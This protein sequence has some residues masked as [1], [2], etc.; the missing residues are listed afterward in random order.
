MR[1]KG[2]KSVLSSQKSPAHGLKNKRYS[3][4]GFYGHMFMEDFCSH[5]AIG[6]STHDHYNF[7]RAN[8]A[9]LRSLLQYD[10]YDFLRYDLDNQLSSVMWELLLCGKSYL[11]VVTKETTDGTLCGISFIPLRVQRA[12]RCGKNYYFKSFEYDDSVVSFKIPISNVIVFDLKDM[13]FGRKYFVRLLRRMRKTDPDLSLITQKPSG[14]SYLERENKNQKQRLKINKRIHWNERNYQNEHISEAYF[15]Y[16][17]VEYKMLRLR[18]LN[19]LIG[20]YNKAVGKIGETSGF[21]G[22][23]EIAEEIPDYNECLEKLQ[24]GEYCFEQASK[25]IFAIPD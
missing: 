3:D 20:K 19:Y 14:T 18:F 10:D 16:R 11:E 7:F 15:L 17:A 8:E 13:G 24:S 1:H 23:I 25:I 5:F 21:G 2:N 6:L 12:L 22:A 4:W 9:T